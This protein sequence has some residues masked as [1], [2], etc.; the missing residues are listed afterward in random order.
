M[1]CDKCKIEMRH[2]TDEEEREYWQ[3]TTEEEQ[4]I[5][6]ENCNTFICPGCG[7]VWVLD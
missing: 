6:D 1:T 3:I 2:M 4:R 7:Y 5:I